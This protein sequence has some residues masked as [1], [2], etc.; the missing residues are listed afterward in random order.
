MKNIRIVCDT[1]SVKKG[2]VSPVKIAI[3]HKGRTILL[4]TGVDV[5]P[6]QFAEG[7]VTHA[8]NRN[9]L[10]AI[11]RQRA[12]AVDN[13]LLAIEQTTPLHHLSPTELRQRIERII[14]P[15]DEHDVYVSRIVDA[16]VD[17]CTGGTQNNYKVFRTQ[18]QNYCKEKHINYHR[19]MFESI[20]RKWIQD[21]EYWLLGR[22]SRNSATKNLGHL[23][24]IFNY[25][26][27]EE[28]ITHYPFRGYR[29]KKERTKSRALSIEQL[30]TFLGAEVVGVERKYRLIFELSLLLLGMNISDIWK[31]ERPKHGRVDYKRNKTSNRYSVKV[32]KRANEILGEIGHPEH[33]TIGS[34]MTLNSFRGNVNFALKR[35]SERLDDFP[36]V[37]SYYARHTWATLAAQIGI[38]RHIIGAAL[39][40]TWTDVTGI[41]IGINEAQVD[42]AS[43]AVEKYIY[44]E[45]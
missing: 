39:G 19:L 7:K 15:Q 14:S 33:L 41:Y 34:L 27:T 32:G 3:P 4:P 45:N 43:E 28:L 8:P 24:T 11:L 6:F 35:I 40:H 38:P 12:N 30:R 2:G 23:R 29:L 9:Q 22:M 17:K 42:E 10:N 18:M 21:F 16:Y 37:T 44:G 36:K 25:A 1:R 26:I 31:A 13:A 20:N 5:L